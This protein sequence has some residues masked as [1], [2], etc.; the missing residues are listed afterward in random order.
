ME[1]KILFIEDEARMRKVVKAYL[2]EEGFLVK[3]AEDGSTGLKL[4]AEF[5]PDLLV[6]DLMLPG[7]SGEEI[8]R[9][10]REKS[11]L[12]ILM[13]TAKGQ[14]SDKVT[15][16]D[17]GAD[18]YL[19]KPFDLAELVVRIKAILRRCSKDDN[20]NLI[21]LKSGKIKLD[22]EGMQA[23]IEGKEIKLTATE[24]K[25]LEVLIKN[26]G[27]VLSREQLIKQAFGIDFDGFDRTIDVHIRKIRDK[28]GLKK[29]EHIITIYGAGYK[30]VGETNE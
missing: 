15:G 10:V 24:F 26:Q 19:V 18:D 5:N 6:L 23:V 3:T 11:S 8:C 25:L 16:F 13:L 27:Q 14:T 20:T 21:S 30:F 1:D 28:L 7:I 22:L 12:P 17:L 9:R 29:D 4:I 2:K